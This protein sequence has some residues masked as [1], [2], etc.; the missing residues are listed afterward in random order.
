VYYISPVGSDPDY[1]SKRQILAEV[2][3]RSTIVFFLPL[4]NH[5]SFSVAQA[6][7]D[8]RISQL[9][10]ADLSLERPSCYFELGLAQ[11][12]GIPVVLL[13]AEGTR[14]HQAGEADRIVSYRD[15]DSYRFAI[16]RAIETLALSKG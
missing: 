4:E 8:L 6:L 1:A 7:A 3:A 14:V 13:A 2:G 15:L 11:A 5:S 10:I 16:E 9:V 12:S